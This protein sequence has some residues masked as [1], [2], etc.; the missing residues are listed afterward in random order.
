MLSD[1][2]E[3]NAHLRSAFEPAVGRLLA[4]RVDIRPILANHLVP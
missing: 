4:L 3:L 2:T 1:E